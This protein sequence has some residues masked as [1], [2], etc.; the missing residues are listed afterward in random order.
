MSTEKKNM[1]D[2]KHLVNEYKHGNQ[3]ALTIL[4]NRYFPYAKHFFESD[5]LTRANAEDLS[6]EVFIKI[7]RAI[8]ICDVKNF[9]KFLYTSLLNKK[10]DAIRKKYHEKIVLVSIFDEFLSEKS[11]DENQQMILNTLAEQ[12][13]EPDADLQYNEL[14]RIVAECIDSF[15]D[16]KR[17]TIVSLKLEGLKENQIADL[18]DLNPHTVNSNWGRGKLQLRECVQR[19]ICMLDE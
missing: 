12:T 13:D 6:Q 16:I 7:S 14:Q 3:N 5:N 9:K 18:L 15:H 8:L 4:F 11:H 2:D 10:R 19:K 17:R 1:D